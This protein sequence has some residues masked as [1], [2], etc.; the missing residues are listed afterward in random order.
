M[1]RKLT[2]LTLNLKLLQ[3]KVRSNF[4]SWNARYVFTWY[5]VHFAAWGNW[6]D[7]NRECTRREQGG[8][9]GLQWVYKNY[10][11]R[12]NKGGWF[13]QKITN[14]LWGRI[15]I[16][17]ILYFF[18]VILGSSFLTLE[19][20]TEALFEVMMFTTDTFVV[21]I[22]LENGPRWFAQ[23]Q[24][25]RSFQR[26]QG[27]WWEEDF[28]ETLE[29]KAEYFHFA[30]RLFSAVYHAKGAICIHQLER[31]KIHK[32]FIQHIGSTV[33]QQVMLLL[34]RCRFSPKF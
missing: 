29:Q 14:I 12:N 9:G 19:R 26:W 11:A 34:H 10:H 23:S 13:C 33:V 22:A 1:F 15:F 27:V 31:C 16:S 32:V 7:T 20:L 5:C 24:I 4:I 8:P 17:L 21:L 18:D 2:S 25:S 3:Q 28:K 30:L 6:A